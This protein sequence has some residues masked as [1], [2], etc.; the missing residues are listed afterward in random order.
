MGQSPKAARN[1][2]GVVP[3][4]RVRTEQLNLTS[5]ERALLPDPRWV[6]EDDADFI[7]ARRAEREPGKRASLE[8]VLL[9][10]R[11]NSPLKIP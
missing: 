4:K 10:N 3:K 5:D 8:Q 9:E 1:G 7:M 11:I 6:T 2:A